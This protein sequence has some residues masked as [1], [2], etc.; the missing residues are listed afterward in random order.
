MATQ[1]L[2]IAETFDLKMQINGAEERLVQLRQSFVQAVVRR[3]SRV[4]SSVDDVSENPPASDD[5]FEGR[6]AELSRNALGNRPPIRC[7]MHD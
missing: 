3:G 6:L 2:N 4:A 5:G 1:A 7:T